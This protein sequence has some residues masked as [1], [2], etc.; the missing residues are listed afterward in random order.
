MK[1]IV[2]SLTCL[3]NQTINYFAGIEK[4]ERLSYK[5]VSEKILIPN[6]F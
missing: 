2:R 1:Q 5:V 3:S 4:H 6:I